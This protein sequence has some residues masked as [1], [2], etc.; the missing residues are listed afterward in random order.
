MIKA[1]IGVLPVVDGA[2]TSSIE[3]SYIKAIEASG[4][5]AVMLPYTESGESIG[6]FAKV[7]DGFIFAGGADIDPKRYG[8][9][10]R[11]VCGELAPLRDAV[12]F[13]AF[14]IIARTGKPVMGICRGMQL[15]NVACGGSLYQDIPSEVGTELLHKQEHPH[16]EPA[17]EVSLVVG[18]LAHTVIGKS[19]THVNSL[20]HQAIKRLGQGLVA[21]VVADDGIIEG[22]A[23]DG[24]QLVWGFQWHPEKTFD[25]SEDSRKIFAYFIDRCAEEKKKGK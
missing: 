24:E 22:I 2:G 7:C 11:D 1:V 6:K 15:I 21:T 25:L 17:H 18:G 10:A 14:E 9:E 16:S 12:E 13:S 5:A 4:G 3:N 23:G 19:R 20:H 8:E